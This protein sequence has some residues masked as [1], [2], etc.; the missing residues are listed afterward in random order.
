MKIVRFNNGEYAIRKFSWLRLEWVYLDLQHILN[1]IRTGICL[2]G[3]ITLWRSTDDRFFHDC[4]D[5]DFETVLHAYNNFDHILIE[6]KKN[7]YDVV[8]V[9]QDHELT[10][11]DSPP[12]RK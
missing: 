7:P 11:M 1:H 5:K 3:L 9:Y 12:K 8:K 6:S 2:E 10:Q 4:V